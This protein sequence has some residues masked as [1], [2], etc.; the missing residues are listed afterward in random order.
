MYI[1]LIK[2]NKSLVEYNK[3]F[4]FPVILGIDINHENY[5]NKRILLI[6]NTAIYGS[7][8]I[9]YLLDN[10]HKNYNNLLVK[11]ETTEHELLF[12]VELIKIKEFDLDFK[13]YELNKLLENKIK[14]NTEDFTLLDYNGTDIIKKINEYLEK[15]SKDLPQKLTDNKSK[16]KKNEQ[17]TIIEDYRDKKDLNKEDNKLENNLEKESKAGS[18]SEYE[19]DEDDDKDEDEDEDEDEDDDSDYNNYGIPIGWNIC[20]EIYEKIVKKKLR[21]NTIKSHLHDCKDCEI[22]NNNN[23]LIDTNKDIIFSNSKKVK[24]IIKCYESC[25]NYKEN[26]NIKNK[27]R[28]NDQMVLLY[29]EDDDEYEK[30]MFFL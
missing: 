20:E 28:E 11:T 30:T 10:N 23:C 19:D 29:D 14:K 9:N 21:K 13:M 5:I 24:D 1:Y 18:D 4:Y 27:I 12:F 15:K 22:I 3:N 25:L 26:K 17:K 8:K 6:K 7:S 16:N 2:T